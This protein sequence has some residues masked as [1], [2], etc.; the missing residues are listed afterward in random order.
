AKVKDYGPLREGARRVRE[1]DGCDQKV[2][3]LSS[4]FCLFISKRPRWTGGHRGLSFCTIRTPLIASVK[5]FVGGFCC[6]RWDCKDTKGGN[7][8]PTNQKAGR[9]GLWN[10]GFQPCLRDSTAPT[11]GP[12]RSKRWAILKHP[13]G[14]TMKAQWHWASVAV[15]RL[16]WGLQ[17]GTFG[18]APLAVQ[19][20]QRRGTQQRG[21][22]ECGRLG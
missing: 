8:R 7:S 1:D 5:T 18:A 2:F 15:V 9:D 12:Q 11:P 13:F 14:M 20:A 4:G 3:H 22:G 6:S 19:Q 10:Q 16:A 21:Q 17:G